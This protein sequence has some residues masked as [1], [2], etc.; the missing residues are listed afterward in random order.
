MILT[1]PTWHPGL[2]IR[3]APPVGLHEMVPMLHGRSSKGK[4]VAVSGITECGGESYKTYFG[5]IGPAPVP[6]ARAF[7]GDKLG[8]GKKPEGYW[9]QWGA[10]VRNHWKPRIERESLPPCV[11]FFAE[12]QWSD[13]VCLILPNG[14]IGLNGSRLV[15]KALRRRSP[16]PPRHVRM[17]FECEK[18]PIYPWPMMN[19]RKIIAMT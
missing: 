16:T 4:G 5:S 10:L 6:V 1:A 19:S 11:I 9:N 15:P 3:K 8:D 13:S 14:R 2:S 7:R 17:L 12:T 18:T